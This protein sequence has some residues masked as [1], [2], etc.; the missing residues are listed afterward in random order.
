MIGRSPC[1]RMIGAAPVDKGAA[2]RLTPPRETALW[3]LL[4]AAGLGREAVTAETLEK[5]VEWARDRADCAEGLGAAAE[6]LY[7]ARRGEPVLVRHPPQDRGPD[8]AASPVN[9]AGVPV[10][11]GGRRGR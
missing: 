3:A 2:F 8:R 1:D 4:R 7:H 9:R 5:A 10:A 11:G 6:L